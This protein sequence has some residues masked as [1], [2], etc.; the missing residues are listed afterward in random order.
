MRSEWG[1]ISGEGH[2]RD[3]RDEMVYLYNEFIGNLDP[4]NTWMSAMKGLHQ[5]FD[6]RVPPLP[7]GS[8]KIP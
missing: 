5:H 3:A 4:E 2:P 7:E 1:K 8:K 6:P